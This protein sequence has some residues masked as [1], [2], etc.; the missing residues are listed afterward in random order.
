MTATISRGEAKR[1][2]GN[3]SVCTGYT[4]EISRVAISNAEGRVVMS[5]MDGGYVSH[6]VYTDSISEA[7]RTGEETLVV[8]VYDK[9]NDGALTA[10]KLFNLKETTGES[11]RR[12]NTLSESGRCAGRQ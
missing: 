8:A 9:S 10:C 6:I 12:D 11:R 3:R 7:D 4:V 1:Y 2:K 5:P